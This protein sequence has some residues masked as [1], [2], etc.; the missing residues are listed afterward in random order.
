MSSSASIASGVIGPFAA[1]L[2][3][4]RTESDFMVD[5]LEFASTPPSLLRA[6]SQ[7]AHLGFVTLSDSKSAFTP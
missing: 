3:A 4:A 6:W 5:L 7:A 1:A 2:L